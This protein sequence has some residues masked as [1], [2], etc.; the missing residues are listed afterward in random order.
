MEASPTPITDSD[1]SEDTAHAV[2]QAHETEDE[3]DPIVY[4][5]ELGSN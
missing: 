4:V 5:A 1:S 3:P 2:T